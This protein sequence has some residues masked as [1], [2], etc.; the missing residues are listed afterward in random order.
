MGIDELIEGTNNFEWVLI[1]LFI[2]TFLIQLGYYLLVFLK[3]PL[4]KSTKKKKSKKS[5]SVVICAKNE[6]EN[7]KRYL[8][9]VLEQEYSEFEVIVVNDC[10]TDNTENL[11]SE[12]S[13]KYKHLRYTT[14]PDNEKFKHGKKLA[15]TI[16][17]KAATYEH[18]LLTDADCY[19][20]S[21]Q[22]LELMAS[23]LTRKK[24]LVL[25]Y[26]GYEHRRSILNLLIRYE[27]VFTA[28]QYLSYALKGRPF[29][30]VGRNLAYEKELFFKN[31]GFASHYHL[32]SGDDDLFVN[33]IAVSENTAV[34]FSKES[35]T[36]SIPHESFKDWF[37]QKKR[38]LSVG[39]YYNR[40]TKIRLGG[41]LMSRFVNYFT[42][43]LLSIL[44]PWM[45]FVIAL[46]GVLMIAKMIIF[47]LGMRRLYEKYLLL[48]SL[49]LDPIMPLLLG[50]IWLS[51]KFETKNQS[52]S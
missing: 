31:K 39:S 37:K 34:E 48:P 24:K 16:G 45:W 36:R 50:I 42:L 9:L 11:L 18:I 13:V 23:N 52:W 29:M 19:P 17:L 49:L 7:L 47:K 14:I 8:P 46:Q 33:E 5:I 26:G 32:S 4:H 43:I 1:G 25:G 44:S 10:S 27:T 41:E 20:V 6:E 2:T 28:I 51:S 12:M 22:W 15:V 3:L 38:H 21:N 35:F 30:G 40:G